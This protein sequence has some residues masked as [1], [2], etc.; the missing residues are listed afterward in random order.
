MSGDNN[1]H[2]LNAFEHQADGSWRCL[3]PVTIETPEA[4]LSIEPG[5]IFVFGHKVR[6]LDVAEY[7]EQLGVQ[8][9]S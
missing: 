6:H 2:I 5:M 3:E 1:I 4:T 8:F 7:L 9:G